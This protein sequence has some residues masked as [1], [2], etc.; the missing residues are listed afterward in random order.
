MAAINDSRAGR[1]TEPFR[2]AVERFISLVGEEP[3]E[4]RGLQSNWGITVEM[5]LKN[6]SGI[7]YASVFMVPQSTTLSDDILRAM[8]D[9]RQSLPPTH[10]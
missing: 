6:S 5:R 9:F 1:Y 4:I 8:T 7:L 3:W 10:I 2:D